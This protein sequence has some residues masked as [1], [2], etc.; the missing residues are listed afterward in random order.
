VWSGAA[1]LDTPNIMDFRQSYVDGEQRLTML[2]RDRAT[3]TIL[4][5]DYEIHNI[6]YVADQDRVNGHELNFVEGGKTVLHMTNNKLDA[7][8]EDK[9]SV[10]LDTSDNCEA[11]FN[12]FKERDVKTGDVLFDWVAHGHIH[13]NESSETDGNIKSRCNTYDFM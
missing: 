4:N 7:T 6:L 9:K 1:Q 5:N 3:G 2:D 11:N 8:D 12:G 10:G 13:L